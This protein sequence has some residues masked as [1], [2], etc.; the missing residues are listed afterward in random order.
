MIRH[1]VR[2]AGVAIGS[3]FLLAAAS[4]DDK[5]F[6]VTH[7]QADSRFLTSIERVGKCKVTTP[8]ETKGIRF[9]W[10]L[11]P[12][13]SVDRHEEGTVTVELVLDA[14]WCVRKAMIVQSSGFWRL[15]NVTLVY[16]MT[17]KYMPR[18]ETIKQKDGEP[19]VVIRLGWG[20]S[21][22]KKK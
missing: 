12:K 19:T 15:D 16:V 20:A 7:S 21:Q 5:Q 2:L 10:Q 3:S 14:E 1:L 11:Y 22:G 4:A 17:I 13:E 8:P 9:P 6:L 18:L